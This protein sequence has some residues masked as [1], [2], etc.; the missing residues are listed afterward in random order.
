MA[1][2]RTARSNIFLSLA[3]FFWGMTF[4]VQRQAMDHLTPM[5]FGGLRFLL[6]ALA[7][8]PLALP[9]AVKIWRGA[10]DVKPLRRMW[11]SGSLAAGLC[12]FVGITLQQYGLLWTTAGKAGFITSL[13]VVLVPLILRLLGHKI[14]L[15]E[16]LGAALAL[17]GLYLLSFTGGLEGLSQGDLLVLISAFVWAGHVLSVGWFAPRMDPVVLGTGQALVCGLLS[18][19]AAGV[20]G[21]WPSLADL[22]ATWFYILWGGFFSVTLGFTFQI[23]G[24][25]DA[26]PALAAIILQMESVVSMLAGWRILDETVTGRMLAG[27]AVML[28]GVLISQLWPIMASR[29]NGRIPPP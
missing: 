16:A 23:V 15:G 7:L 11:L 21:Q 28:A 24:Q 26:K 6:G 13:Y 4:I 18:L 20:L 1:I 22:A 25:K 8:M 29:K 27:A 9:R 2:S 3:A 10:D 19:A 17:A 14:V 5:A 12:L